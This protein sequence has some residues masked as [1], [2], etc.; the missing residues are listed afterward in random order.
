MA[1]LYKLAGTQVLQRH[2]TVNGASTAAENT[3]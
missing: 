2:A 3:Q 1:A